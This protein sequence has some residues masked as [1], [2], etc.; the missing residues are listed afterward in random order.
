VKGALHQVA[1][2]EAAKELEGQKVLS[3]YLTG[4][5]KLL[6]GRHELTLKFYSE[7]DA[8]ALDNSLGHQRKAGQ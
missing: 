1:F 2:C 4:A 5:P 3:R 8:D 7:N 6:F